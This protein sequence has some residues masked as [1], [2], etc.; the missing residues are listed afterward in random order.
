MSTSC[1]VLKL[2]VILTDATSNGTS[3]LPGG[4]SHRAGLNSARRTSTQILYA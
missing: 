4:E 3:N 1:T 2:T